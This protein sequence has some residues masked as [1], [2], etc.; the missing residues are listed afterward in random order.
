MTN[1]KTDD[2]LTNDVEEE[3]EVED[4]EEEVIEE[5][6]EDTVET[7]EIENEN[8]Q[9]LNQLEQDRKALE[10]A[11]KRYK[12]KAFFGDKYNPD[13][14]RVVLISD[15]SSE[16]CGGTHVSSTGEIGLMKIVSESSL[17][18]G[19]RRIEAVT[20]YGALE[21]F[22][23]DFS[24][25]S[26]VEEVPGLGDETFRVDDKRFQRMIAIKGGIMIDVLTPADPNLQ[27]QLLRLVLDKI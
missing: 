26:R 7:P 2:A 20:G 9:K 17:S 11:K 21:T 14:V 3:E 15:F 1:E 4:I 10:D 16:L 6:V 8:S 19:I 24:T 13:S 27:K 22:Q 18:T 12:A 25:V 23:R 5:V